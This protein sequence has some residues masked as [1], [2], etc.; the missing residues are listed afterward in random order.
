MTDLD[1]IAAADER[2]RQVFTPEELR[3]L[4]TPAGDLALEAL[5]RSDLAKARQIC[6]EAKDMHRVLHDNYVVWHSM[7]AANIV[8][9]YGLEALHKA[10][11]AG[12]APWFRAIAD[13]FRDG[14]TREAVTYIMQIWRMY[15]L[16][17]GPVIEDDETISVTLGGYGDFFRADQTGLPAEMDITDF[18][19]AA[20]HSRGGQDPQI[21]SFSLAMLYAEK[22]MA[23][24]LGYP[25]FVHDFHANGAPARL[26]IYKD[27]LA[28]PL[29]YF[30]RI[31]HRHDARRIGGAVRVKGGRLFS[32]P[33]LVELG[34]QHMQRAVD[35]IDDGDLDAARGWAQLSK[36]EW[37]PAH[38]VHRDWIT[39]MLGWVYSNHG[40]D[41][42]YEAVE[43]GYE[44]PFVSPMMDVVQTMSL[45]DQVEGLAL[46][47]RQHA[48]V[49]RVEEYD[50]RIVFVTE[51]CGSGGR[52]QQEGAYDADGPVRFP[53]IAERHKGTFFLEDFP[54]YCVHCPSTNRMLMGRGGPYYL[55]V[56]GDLMQVQ[57]GNCNFYI[58]KD[59]AAVP[60]R[61][62]KRAGLER[63]ECGS[64]RTAT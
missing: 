6:V 4:A 38:H 55:M 11:P 2:T 48:M 21:P 39:G 40:P 16:D 59:P 27:P 28:I 7:N 9:S 56:D 13:R 45:R 43:N 47:F 52:L 12:I 29:S 20:F 64:C 42:V 58:F 46:G 36:G 34:R 54:V 60:D 31:G 44:K 23:G 35:A 62:Y 22:L 61:F 63:S 15:C 26:R 19:L 50:D 25:A 24:W 49:F 14:V 53:K 17:L 33:E 51:P 5:D 1:V 37:Y 32:R 41:A 10:L 30:E 8:R 3:L 18:S 57:D